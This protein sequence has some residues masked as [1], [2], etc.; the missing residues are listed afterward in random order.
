MSIAPR[1][2]RPGIFTRNFAW[3]T[4][5]PG[6]RKLHEAIRVGF[7]DTAAD[8]ERAIFLSRIGS[9]ANEFQAPIA[10]NFFLFNYILGGVDYLLAD[11]LVRQAIAAPHSE[12][13]DRLALFAFLLSTAG[14]WHNSE[15]FHAHPAEWAKHFVVTQI[16]A[17]ASWN[18][19]VINATNIKNYIESNKNYKGNWAGKASTNLKH[20]FDLGHL[21]KVPH[22]VSGRWRDRGIFLAIDRLSKDKVWGTP[23]TGEILQALDQEHVF[24]LLGTT[25]YDGGEAA[26]LLIGTYVLEGAANRTGTADML[27]VPLNVSYQIGTTSGDERR[28]VER[29]FAAANRQVRDRKLVAK[30]RQYYGDK[31]AVCGLAI[32]LVAKGVTFCEVGHV[33]P[34]G[35]PINGPD[36]ESNMLPFCPNHHKQFDRGAIVFEVKG[37]TAEVLDRSH[38]PTYSG[39]VFAP[40]PGHVFDMEHLKWHKK[41]FS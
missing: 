28:P 23:N 11:E 17:R 21:A 3:G 31:C 10:T 38:A 15:P 16:A 12:D 9:L 2:W 20:L 25:S 14:Q 40:A 34:V 1:N 27:T 5:V 29:I 30:I 18:A 4:V 37:T 26:K 8:V 13:F 24:T 19:G 7:N 39:R 35:M 41:W 36:H 32:P 6:L 22:E 33:K